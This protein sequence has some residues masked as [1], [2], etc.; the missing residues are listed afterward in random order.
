MEVAPVIWIGVDPG[1]ITGVSF[2]DAEGVYFSVEESADDAIGFLKHLT[3]A[4]NFRIRI[5]CEQYVERGNQ[6]KTNQ[7][8]AQRVTGAVLALEYPVT[9]IPPSTAKRMCDDQR[10]KDLG[11]Y[12]KTKDGHSND[13]GR[14]LLATIALT[15][16]KELAR[17]IP[18]T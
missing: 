4:V 5:G 6:R 8:L 17:L 1:D 2:L 11:W 9:L 3:S 16:P 18:S 13:A 7:P 10:L 15:S 12:R 14:V